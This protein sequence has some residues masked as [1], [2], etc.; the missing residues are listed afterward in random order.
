M[1]ISYIRHY[2]PVLSFKG[3]PRLPCARSCCH[4]HRKYTS[5]PWTVPWPRAG[6]RRY[7]CSWCRPRPSSLAGRAPGEGGHTAPV[8]G[9]RDRPAGD[10]VSIPRHCTGAARPK[11]AGQTGCK[12]GVAPSMA[13]QAK[14]S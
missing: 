12:T 2:Q 1:H 4:F 9:G 3:L 14:A 10:G 7:R 6:A 5:R 11:A 8:T 13:T